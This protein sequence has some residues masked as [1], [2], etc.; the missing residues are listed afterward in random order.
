MI[1]IDTYHDKAVAVYGLGRTG[2]SAARALIAG[3]ARVLVWDDDPNRRRDAV[4]LGAEAAAPS[5][6]A[7]AGIMALILS[8]GVP[9]THP[10]PHMVVGLA[11]RLGAEVLGDVEL[12]ARTRPVAA[13]ATITGTNGK[14]TTTSLLRHILSTAGRAVQAGANLGLPVLDFD[15][16]DA[17]GTYVLELSSY[18]IDLTTG[19][20]PQ[21]VALL[22]ISPDH[23]DRHGGMD[24][25][26]AAKRRLLQMA[27]ADAVLVLGSD[28]EW[29]A[30][31][32]RNMRAAGRKVVE[33]AIGREIGSEIEDGLFVRDGRLYRA[34]GA[35]PVTDLNGIETLRGAHN[36]QNAA[37]AFAMA[38]ALG[39]AEARIIPAL[40]TYPGLPHRMEVVA[41][42]GDIL[43]V[44]DSKAT[45]AAA[46]AHALAA[47]ENIFWIAGGIAKQGGID[48]LAPYF[49]NITRA[50]LI[51]EAAESFA[52]KLGA[53]LVHELSGDLTTAVRAAHENAVAA[54]GGVVLLSPACASFDQFASF[55]ARGD[56]FHAL[57]QSMIGDGDNGDNGEQRRAVGGLG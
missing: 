21:V 47:Y 50:F 14:S 15:N 56:Q 44:N 51:G 43:F 39:L 20:R 13:V 41:R 40:R 30:Q 26:I 35:K 57:A 46:A 17:T 38:E 9:L 33:V 53:G 11:E 2:L 7:W 10:K 45:N 25:Y 12:F 48:A 29:S 37:V 23:L 5:S 3:G 55:E 8:P 52:E 36:W 31:I 34:G 22:N 28:D 42:Q 16:V 32:C 27:D 54:G 24:G 6:E 19:L 18:Q 1:V 4:V 49:A